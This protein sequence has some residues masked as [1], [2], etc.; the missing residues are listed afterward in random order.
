ME[1]K[2]LRIQNKIKELQEKLKQ[3]QERKE[4]EKNKVDFIVID[5]WAYETQDHDKGKELS[6][7]KIPGGKELWLPSEC[8]KFYENKELRDKLNLSDCW[9]FVKQIRENTSDV[10]RFYADSVSVDLGTDYDSDDSGSYLGV[11]FKWKVKK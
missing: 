4:V 5:G 1:D 8:W 6:E 2:E 3:I 7:I 10:A 11:R 9:F